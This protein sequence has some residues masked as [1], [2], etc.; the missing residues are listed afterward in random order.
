MVISDMGEEGEGGGVEKVEEE[1][2][3]Q[4]EVQRQKHTWPTLGVK[5]EGDKLSF[6]K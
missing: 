5:G 2:D 6:F 4:K 3:S 1:L